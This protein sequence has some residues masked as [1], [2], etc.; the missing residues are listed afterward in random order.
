[1][2]TSVDQVTQRR[3]GTGLIAHD[4]ARA[5][6]GFTVV[7]P[8]TADGNVYLIDSAGTVVHRWKLPV[9]PGRAAVLLPNGNLGYNGS[10][11]T[12]LDFYP[13]WSMWH[14]GDF[15][16]VTPHG[17]VVWRYEDPAHHH[18]ARWLPDGHLLY[19]AAE[20]LPVAIA[21]RVV[22]GTSAGVSESIFGDVI[23]EVDRNGRLVWEWRV[24][25]H[26]DPA[27]FPIQVDF[28]RFH[29]PL[30]NGLDVTREGLV[31]MSLRTTSGLIAVERTSGRVVHHI[32]PEV[33]SHQHAPVAL[34]NGRI[35]L[36]DNGNFR[37]GRAYAHSRVIEVDP[38]TGSVVWSYADT[39]AHAFYS[40]YMGSAQRLWNG[41]THITESASGRL[42]EVT[43]AGE[44]VWEYIVPWFAEFPAP[45]D[46]YSPGQHNS[47]FQ[48]SRY[49]REEISWLQ[50]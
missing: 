38:A 19:A 2:S 12:S 15:Q 8:L 35:L 14:G 24:W 18:D 39:P 48:T 42:F 47:V 36:F 26:L 30:I 1:M 17:E 5:A 32:P 22:G 11:R 45:A 6:G 43:P 20:P 10:H 25:E 3:R 44:V 31:L 16:E 50:I 21:K 46:A 33:V 29:W 7:A 41:N 27:G 9:R 37:R 13:A 28:P 40:P 4:P 23:R 49:R 34:P